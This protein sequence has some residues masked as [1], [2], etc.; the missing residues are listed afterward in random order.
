MP[1][2]TAGTRMA[3][4]QPERVHRTPA[5]IEELE[6][7]TIMA[8]L[9]DDPLEFKDPCTS[10]VPAEPLPELKRVEEIEYTLR[11]T[12]GLP[13]D[14]WEMNRLR[15]IK[16][17][18][19]KPFQK[20]VARMCMSTGFDSIPEI[21][22]ALEIGRQLMESTSVAALDKIA[23]GNM[24]VNCAK[25]LKE[26]LAEVSA[27]SEKGTEGKPD[28]NGKARNKP[29]IVAVQVNYPPQQSAGANNGAGIKPA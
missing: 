11:A 2:L 19:N 27:L 5:E 10:L 4:E 26:M 29:P 9:T 15:A 23:A 20:I 16:E 6:C 8:D 17:L 24:I 28:G 3:S 18:G 21:E 25:A 14:K 22:R 13:K 1:H 12:L 7:R